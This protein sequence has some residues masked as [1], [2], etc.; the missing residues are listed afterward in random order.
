MVVKRMTERKR[1]DDG[2]TKVSS[3]TSRVIVERVRE[4]EVENNATRDVDS[5]RQHVRI[6]DQYYD[7]DT[8][9]KV[10]PDRSSKQ[11]PS[12]RWRKV[13]TCRCRTLCLDFR[14]AVASRLHSYKPKGEESI[15]ARLDTVK[16]PKSVA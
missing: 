15:G 3:I 14:F 6:E 12:F 11:S 8:T 13:G 9:L 4:E 5:R 2:T 10:W 16:E 7:H 1:V